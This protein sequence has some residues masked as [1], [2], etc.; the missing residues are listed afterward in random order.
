MKT[1]FLMLLVATITS[2]QVSTKRQEFKS[3]C[4]L[5]KADS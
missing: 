2:C 4:K 5:T 1:I 3:H